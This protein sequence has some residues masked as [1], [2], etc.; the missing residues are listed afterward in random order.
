M[1]SW[2]TS[3]RVLPTDRANVQR[4]QAILDAAVQL[5]GPQ[6]VAVKNAQVG[7]HVGMRGDTVSET[8][9]FF[10]DVGL[11]TTETAG[12]TYAATE[13]GWSLCQVWSEDDV[14][15][16]L[17]LHRCFRQHWSADA[18]FEA[19]G[20]GSMSVDELG[21]RLHEG[22]PGKERRGTYLVEWLVWA[23]VLRRDQRGQ[24][25]APGPAENL[26]SLAA[27]FPAPAATP[28]LSHSAL[29]FGMAPSDLDRLPDSEYVETL[30]RVTQGFQW[31][32]P[33]GT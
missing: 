17:I 6:R 27:T 5:G 24:V 12:R 7:R 25:S 20:S 32:R 9:R 3:A 33:S 30:R 14:Q 10:N 26:D 28:Q 15:A 22:H 2:R 16:R 23:L 21:R 1:N 13:A 19:L 11:L 18:A 4:Q 29:F 8:L 31:M